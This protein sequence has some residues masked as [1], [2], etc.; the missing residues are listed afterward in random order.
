MFTKAEQKYEM[1]PYGRFFLES[2]IDD[3]TTKQT[4]AL[5]Y[6]IVGFIDAHEVPKDIIIVGAPP[7]PATGAQVITPFKLS[8]SG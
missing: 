8:P 7:V 5:Q 3:E 1:V 2:S 6:R 4:N